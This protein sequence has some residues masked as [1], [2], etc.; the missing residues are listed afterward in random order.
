MDGIKV[1]VSLLNSLRLKYNAD[2]VKVYI[3][4]ENNYHIKVIRDGEVCTRFRVKEKE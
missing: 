3:S 4:D 2:E 1:I